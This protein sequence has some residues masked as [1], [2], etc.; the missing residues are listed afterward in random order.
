MPLEGECLPCPRAAAAQQFEDDF[1]P[2]LERVFQPLHIP[3]RNRVRFA[4]ASMRQRERFCGILGHELLLD[5]LSEHSLEIDAAAAH[6]IVAKA[7]RH[8]IQ[9]SLQPLLIDVREQCGPEFGTHQIEVV[10]QLF[11]RSVVPGRPANGDEFL[12]EEGLERWIFGFGTRS[13]R[14]AD[15]LIMLRIPSVLCGALGGKIAL[16]LKPEHM[17]TLFVPK[18][19]MLSPNLLR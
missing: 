15:H 4:F 11:A 9:K 13:A 1:V 10:A 16:R 3:E 5:G 19:T 18:N 8:A 12:I 14:A 6:G 17:S 2:T 7:V